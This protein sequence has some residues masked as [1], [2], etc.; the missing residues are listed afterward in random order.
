MKKFLITSLLLILC[1]IATMAQDES[2]SAVENATI[3]EQTS[4]YMATRGYRGTAEVSPL[5]VSI[6]GLAFKFGTTHGFQFN[7]KLFLGGGVGVIKYYNNDEIDIPVYIAIQ[8]NVGKNMAQFTY[9][10]R[11]GISVYSKHYYLVVN[12]Q[13][14]TTV[15]EGPGPL[16]FNFNLGLRLG[17][18]PQYAMTIKPELE[19][20]YCGYPLANLGL[21]LGFE[22]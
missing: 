18:T 9:G 16:Y 2:T 3:E 6:G 20:I 7:H 10:G 8:S 15:S 19:V 13:P 22:F 17:F 5:T 21:N 14:T 1:S 11:L 4:L 12:N